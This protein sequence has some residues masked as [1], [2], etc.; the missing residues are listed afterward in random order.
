MH[1]A[2]FC[3]LSSVPRGPVACLHP[4]E[5]EPTVKK[6]KRGWRTNRPTGGP[7]LDK[8]NSEN[9]DNVS[10]STRLRKIGRW[11]RWTWSEQ[12]LLNE[13][14]LLHANGG[15]KQRGQIHMHPFQHWGASKNLQRQE[16][17]GR[18]DED[19]NRNTNQKKNSLKTTCMNV[20]MPNKPKHSC[21]TN[22]NIR[23][24]LSIPVFPTSRYKHFY[25]H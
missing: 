7:P 1:H 21:F 6:V 16:G 8:C 12:G 14:L 20:T 19:T 3:K 24:L 23:V 15:K 5:V 10:D 13:H 17:W 9:K 22:V 25:K 18:G 11:P 4:K 2:G